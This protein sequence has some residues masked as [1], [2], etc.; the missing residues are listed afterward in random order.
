MATA[1]EIRVISVYAGYEELSRAAA[2]LFVTECRQTVRER[3]RFSV[4]LSGGH[5]PRHTYELLTQPEYARRVP[6]TDVHVFWTDERC[7]SPDDP[8]SNQRMAHEALLDHV[9]I[10]AH[11][12][13]PI[14]CAQHPQGAAERRELELRKFFADRTPRFDLIILGLGDNGHT[15]SLFP[16][17]TVLKDRERW[18]ADVHVPGEGP[19]RVTMTAPLINQARRVVFLVSGAKKAQALH[20]VLEGPLDP[21]RLPAQL[22]KPTD[23]Q[24]VWLVDR[25]AAAQLKRRAAR[26]R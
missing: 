5:T 7:V 10:P 6:W 26:S 14:L 12:V 18:V 11:Q 16:G 21:N 3:G 15:A 24:L 1:S 17:S 23:G 22:I 4:V 13:H 8:E 9:P 2:E 20:E 19:N 25:A